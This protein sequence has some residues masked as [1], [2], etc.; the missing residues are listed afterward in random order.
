MKS[1][2]DSYANHLLNIVSQ[3]PMSTKFIFTSSTSVYPK[4]SGIYHENSITNTKS[5]I[6]IAEIKLNKLLGQRL[7]ILRLGG[8]YGES[9][10]PAFSLQGRNEIKNPN[11]VIN[12]V[13]LYDVIESIELLISKHEFGSIFNIVNPSHPNRKEYYLELVSLLN[14]KQITFEE[15]TQNSK[16]R[17]ID[18]S[19]FLNTLNTTFKR[20]IYPPFE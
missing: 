7:T 12:F 5:P 9:R 4:T 8:L 15:E 13:H 1:T 18:S 19:K 2:I 16:L 11:G 6:R 17:I 10:H 20:S 14:L 3:F